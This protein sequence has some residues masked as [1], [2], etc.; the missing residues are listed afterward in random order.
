MK[1]L[2]VEPSR[3]G[4]WSLMLAKGLAQHGGVQLTIV[5]CRADLKS[6]QERERKDGIDYLYLKA[7][8]H[9]VDLAALYRTRIAALHRLLAQEAPKHQ[10]LHLHGTEHQYHVASRGI[11]IPQVVSMQGIMQE[12]AKFTRPTHWKDV[13][14]AAWRLAAYYER[15]YLGHIN[16]FSCRTHLDTSFVKS[17]SPKAHIH[18]N[19]EMIR[20]EFFGD[21]FSTQKKKLLFT[22]GTSPIKGIKEVL[23]AFDQLRRDTDLKLMI[24]GHIDPAQ[25]QRLIARHGL[26]HIQPN[27][28]E[29]KGYQN[30]E[31]MAKLFEEA[32]C[33]L[34]PSY[35]DNSPNTVC[36]AQIAGLPVVAS[37]VGGVSSLV[38]HRQTGML[39]N[40]N[41]NEVAQAV[42][43]LYTNNGLW[44]QLSSQGAALARKR[45]HAPDIVEKTIDMYR[46]VA[47]QP[48]LVAL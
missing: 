48:Q 15:H 32:F 20:P 46:A 36:E 11:D 40:V 10:V 34:H 35:V 16:H 6:A 27:D 42:R 1:I 26:R 7:P 37:N 41:A 47:A 31:G 23:Q 12:C 44:W 22:G 38:A 25:I 14:F 30:A 4:P 39:V 3:P 2:W 21:H 33:L 17:V 18:T 9:L 8:H 5:R 19:W 24:S 28:I 43:E 29:L 45:H 13:R